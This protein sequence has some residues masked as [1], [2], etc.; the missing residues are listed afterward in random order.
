[1]ARHNVGLFY[2]FVMKPPIIKKEDEYYTQGAMHI[3]VISG[4]RKTG[5]NDEDKVNYA[6]PVI[7]S[8]DSDMVR[9]MA[10]LQEND[11]V[12]V[13]GMISTRTH[14]KLSQCPFCGGK[15][16]VN[17]VLTYIT[18]ISINLEHRPQDQLEAHELLSQHREISNMVSLVGY[19][20]N[21][22][23]TY[24]SP[25]GLQTTEY[26]IAVNR[27]FKVEADGAE[28]RTDYPW[29]YSYGRV[30]EA[31]RDMLKTGTSV[32][33]EGVF[34]TDE[35]KSKLHCSN[36]D[37]EQEYEWDDFNSEIV[38]YSTDYLQNYNTPEET[39]M[40]HIKEVRAREAAAMGI[41]DTDN[42]TETDS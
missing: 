11:I 41:G 27:K 17:G 42:T 19:V 10:T 28:I 22:I 40:I 39:E 23:H 20:C 1:M 12:I 15:N 35:F 38:A 37:C 24:R 16:V 36:P 26:E 31:D 3:C 25:R 8:Q 18:P 14:Q 5:V 30:A 4:Y 13:K 7:F 6:C 34:R 33:V 32:F 2:G 21:D 29:I 9:T